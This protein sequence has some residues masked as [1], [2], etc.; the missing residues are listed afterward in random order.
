MTIFHPYLRQFIEIFIDDFAI[1]KSVADHLKCLYLTFQRCRETNLKLHPEKCFFVV[2]QGT[3]LGHIV[4]TRGIEID[5]RKILI[6]LTIKF[7]TNVREVRGFIGCTGY[8]RRFI[9]SYANIACPL[10]LMLRKDSDF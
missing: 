8:Y 3:L 1:Y 5:K 4:S 9:R 6:W 2:Q 10:N 7:P